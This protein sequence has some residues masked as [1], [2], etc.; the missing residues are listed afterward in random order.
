MTPEEYETQK[1]RLEAN[2]EDARKT[3]VRAQSRFDALRSE[4]RELRFAW[5]EQQA[6]AQTE[7]RSMRA[8]TVKQK[9]AAPAG[10]STWPDRVQARRNTAVHAASLEPSLEVK[11]ACRRTYVEESVDFLN[12]D[13]PITCAKC[14]KAIVSGW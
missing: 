13:D 4:L 12:E 2:A 11:T 3:L 10:L 5:Q 9:S 7:G 6:N 1:R 8:P 14:Q